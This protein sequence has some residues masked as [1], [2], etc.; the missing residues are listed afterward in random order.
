M[1]GVRTQLQALNS[2]K[3]GLMT[4]R[5]AIITL[6]DAAKASLQE[7]LDT[8]KALRG[9]MRYRDVT[10]IDAAIKELETKIARTSMS[11]QEEKKIMA[12]IKVSW[13]N[14]IKIKNKK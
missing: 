5:N 14:K 4:E 7:K 9:D 1:D 8:E 10:S 2:E 3:G 11:L 13:K 12:E 6:C